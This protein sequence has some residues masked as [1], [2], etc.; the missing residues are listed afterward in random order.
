MTHLPHPETSSIVDGEK[1]DEPVVNGFTRR[2]VLAGAAAATAAV[3]IGAIDT[4]AS[5]QT[6]EE[7]IVFVQLSAALT[8]IAP[9]KLAAPNFAATVRNSDPVDIKRDYFAWVNQR[10]PALL[11]R[12]LQIARDSQKPPAADPAKAIIDKVQAAPDTKYLARSI[13]LMW[14]LGAWYD[15][16]HLQELERPNPP[17][18]KFKVISS[19]AYTQGWVWRVAQAHP[20]GFSE[21][22]FGYWARPPSLLRPDFIGN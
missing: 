10:H 14:Y 18:L 6:P 7:M 2:G 12:L 16:N 22:Q 3:S 13:V 4:P 11:R 8:G 15:P 5:A 19:K 21:M 1:E 9:E 17:P 20:M